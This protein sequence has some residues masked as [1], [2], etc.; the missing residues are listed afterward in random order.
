ME[1]M[2]EIATV[3]LLSAVATEVGDEDLVEFTVTAT[4][5]SQ[6]QAGTS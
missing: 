3:G 5:K 6:G 1:V 4:V 2:P